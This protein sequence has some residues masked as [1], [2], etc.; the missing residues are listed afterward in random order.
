[1]IN[2]M[3]ILR[4]VYKKDSYYSIA[5]SDSIGSLA[6]NAFDKGVDCILKTQYI[7]KNKL[8]SWCA[9][10]HY[11][12]LQPVMARSYELASL[13]GAESY[14]IIKLLMSLDNPSKDIRRA[15]YGAV[16]WY[17]RSRI[18]GQ[19]LESFTNSDGKSDKRVVADATAADMWARFYTLSDNRPFFC[20][21]DGIVKYSLAEIGYER[22]NGYSWY[23]TTGKDVMKAYDSW[24][25]KWGSTIL[26]CPLKNATFADTSAIPFTVFANKNTGS[27]L[28]KM[29]LML[30]GQPYHSFAKTEVDTLLRGIK[31]GSH[32]FVVSAEYLNG[33]IESDTVAFIVTKTATA[34]EVLTA[35]T[36]LI[37]SPTASKDGFL[38]LMEGSLIHQIEVYNLKSQRI[39]VSSPNAD[40]TCIETGKLVPGLYLLRVCDERNRWQVQKIMV[41][42]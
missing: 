11:Q 7:Q 5:L 13:S 9:Q 26:A 14:N 37:C 34:N 39:A 1:M 6:I 18:K 23:N 16:S 15:I 35:N 22:R 17:D 24:L 36:R 32:T 21:R 2:V 33:H 29:E 8:V 12:T 19:R 30:D 28:K 41:Q 27:S 3:E 4:R 38:L 31:A 20:D 42:P 25:P 40:A 10:H